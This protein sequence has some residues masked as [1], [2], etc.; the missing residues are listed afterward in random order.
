MVI[1]RPL[2]E[3]LILYIENDGNIYRQIVQPTIN[4]YAKRKLKGTYKKELAIKGILNIVEVGRRKYVREFGL[5][6]QVSMDTKLAVA[7]GLFPMINEQA[8]FE[9][10]RLRKQM[11]AKKKLKKIVRKK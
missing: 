7:R 4:N 8:T 6:G 11:M 1:D 3:E 10:K 5:L 2:A 9:A